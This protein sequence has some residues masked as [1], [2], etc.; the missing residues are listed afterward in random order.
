MPTICFVTY[1]IHPTNKGGCGVLLHHAAEI[2]LRQG[3]TIIFL[4]DVP[5]NEFVQF[6]ERDR[7]GFPRPENCSAYW[8]DD[9]LDGFPLHPADVPNLFRLKSL[10]FAYA[11]RRLMEREPIDLVEFFEYAGVGYSAFVDRIFGDDGGQPGKP[12]AGAA[13]MPV[14]AARLHS[15]L[16]LLDIHGGTH[17]MDRDRHFLYGL[18]RAALQLTETIIAPTRTFF[19]AHYEGPYRLPGRRMVVAQSPKQPFPAVSRRPPRDGPYRIAFIGRMFALKG[20]DQLVQAAVL[21]F[22]RRPALRCCVDL[23]GY[24]SP[25][26]PIPGSFVAY[27]RTLMPA[28]LR[29]RFVFYGQLSHAQIIERLGDA[30][31][32]V[33]PN[34]IESFCYALHEVY[35]AGVPV[36]VNNLPAFA[37]FFEHERNA[38]VYDGTTEG[39]LSAMERMIDDAALRERLRRPYAVAE[40]PLGEIYE[41]PRALQPLVSMGAATIEATVLILAEEGDGDDKVSATLESLRSQDRPAEEIYVLRSSPAG[42]GEGVWML[43]RCWH[44]T[45]VVPRREGHS[46]GASEPSASGALSATDLLTRDAI[47]L[48]AAGDRLPPAWLRRCGGAL[49]RRPQLPFAGTWRRREGQLFAP[50]LDTCPEAWPFEE[51]TDRAR[52]LLRTAPRRLVVDLFDPLLG[53][54]GEMGYLWRLVAARG[55]GVLTPLPPIEVVPTTRDCAPPADAL[56]A[57]LSRYGQPFAERIA[58]LAGVLRGRAAGTVLRDG[59]P[60]HPQLS[61]EQK[62]AIA[63]DLNGK[64]LLR[65]AL[66]KFWQKARRIG[67]KR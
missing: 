55:P 57:L 44:V 4:L 64:S 35:D 36:V 33:F 51:G 58:Q 40:Q 22:R 65:L 1:E 34:R 11:L 17:G 12:P 38:L 52:V 47:L 28:E 14:L 7:L 43:G 9:L 18:E 53:A 66:R 24:D 60:R 37:D 67:G 54:L 26:S 13:K 15:S 5:R 63:A 19:T 45:R 27:L 2:L 31:F 39:L 32:A 6:A 23:I 46:A 3:H 16:E 21:L 30:H 10:R 20:V 61:I 62:R 25:E 29:D 41:H 49:A 42:A 48:L 56:Q 50:Q 8:V 59:E